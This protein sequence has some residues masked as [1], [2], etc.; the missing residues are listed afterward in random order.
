MFSSVLTN[1]YRLF[2]AYI[3]NQQWMNYPPVLTRQQFNLS[4]AK[5]SLD[6][7][8]CYINLTWRGLTADNMNVEQS[9]DDILIHGPFRGANPVL[10]A[11][12]RRRVRAVLWHRAGPLHLQQP[13]RRIHQTHQAGSVSL[14]PEFR[15]LL[16]PP[17]HGAARLGR[18]MAQQAARCDPNQGCERTPV[19]TLRSEFPPGAGSL[20]GAD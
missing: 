9:E 4:V 17:P 15:T 18:Q 12:R 19:L 6:E 5:A 11:T 16:F 20:E 10:C 7:V 14:S 1:T 13:L 8:I 2:S 3:I